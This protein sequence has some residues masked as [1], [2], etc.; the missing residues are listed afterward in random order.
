M[1][2]ALRDPWSTPIVGLTHSVKAIW[3]KAARQVGNNQ[4]PYFPERNAYYPKWDE[5]VPGLIEAME[6]L[7]V[8][9]NGAFK[10]VVTQDEIITNVPD[11]GSLGEDHVFPMMKPGVTMLKEPDRKKG[12]RIFIQDSKNLGLNLRLQGNNVYDVRKEGRTEEETGYW[13]WVGN[14][15]DG[16]VRVLAT[17]TNMCL[18]NSR[19]VAPAGQQNNFQ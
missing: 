10:F 5:K 9:S 7:S 15:L 18:K 6:E 2:K 19:G 12:L 3:N 11:Q 14:N 16:V 17:K 1:A 4:E 13:A 8:V